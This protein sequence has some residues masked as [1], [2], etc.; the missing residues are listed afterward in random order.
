MPAERMAP[1]LLHK[2]ENV[3]PSRWVDMYLM[4]VREKALEKK[5]SKPFVLLKSPMGLAWGTQVLT[6]QADLTLLDNL[7]M[8][9]V[10]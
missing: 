6:K 7:G 8:E 10:T 5:G 2:H 3:S 4:S 1:P 9:A